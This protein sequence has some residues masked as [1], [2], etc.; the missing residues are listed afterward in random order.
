[1]ICLESRRNT[2]ICER[3]SAVPGP[4]L[5]L[6]IDR[7]IAVSISFRAPCHLAEGYIPFLRPNERLWRSI[8]L[9][10]SPL[11]S[12]SHPPLP[13][14][15]GSSLVKK[16]DGSLR[17]CIDYRG[18]NDITVKNRYPLPLMSSAFEILQ[19]AKIFTKLDLRNAYHLVRIKEGDEW[20]TAFNT[21]VGHFE[22]R[23]LP[24]VLVNAPAVFQALVNDVLRDMINVFVFV[25]LDDILI[26]SPSLQV[27]VQH[28]RR[29]LQRL[30][31]NRLFVKAEKC[32][33]H[34]R[35]VTFLGSVVS[36]EGISMDPDKV[37]AVIEWP[38]PDSRIALQRFL[39]FANFYRQFIRS[40]SQVAAPLTAL[41][42][43]S[44][45]FT[46]SEVAQ[47]AF[48]HLKRLFT[49]APILITPDPTRQFIVEVD[50]SDVGKHVLFFRIASHPR[51]VIMMSV[52]VNFWRSV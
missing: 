10:L 2:S 6:L 1:M 49:S 47:N 18:L 38:V 11:R 17:P 50:A 12:L 39:G 19:G 21:P 9:S 46:W 4:H 45:H 27:H 24:F 43:I 30:F 31:E 41:T 48:D 32:M 13:P 22:Y 40:F 5:C 20:K 26:F 16:K 42:S 35:S 23:V 34:S 7:T 15:R 8:S 14:G 36:A 29:V 25:Y 28:V 52:T 33:F 3:F 44:S 51:S 37:H